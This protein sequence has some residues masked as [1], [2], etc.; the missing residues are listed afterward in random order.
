MRIVWENRVEERE[1]E[2]GDG[3]GGFVASTLQVSEE[4]TVNCKKTS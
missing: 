3:D 4:V 2:G 1:E